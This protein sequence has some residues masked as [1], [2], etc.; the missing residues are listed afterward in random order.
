MLDTIFVELIRSGGISGALI[1]LALLY[2]AL[3]VRGLQ[4]SVERVQTLI[5]KLETLIG[6]RVFPALNSHE[7]RISNLE[8]HYEVW[9]VMRDTS[10]GN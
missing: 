8:G 6:E 5:E 10:K 2:L 4:H 1:A 7:G 3:Q 9:Q